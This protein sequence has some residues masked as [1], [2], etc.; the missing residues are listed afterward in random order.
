MNMYV[1]VAAVI[2]ACLVVALGTSLIMWLELGD[3]EQEEPLPTR[4]DE[5]VMVHASLRRELGREPTTSEL[6]GKAGYGC[7]INS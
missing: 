3:D 2:M 7:E 5:L 1:L 6:W 4:Y